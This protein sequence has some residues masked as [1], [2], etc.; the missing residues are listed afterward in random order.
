MSKDIQRKVA[1]L[2]EGSH[3]LRCHTVPHFGEYSVGKHSYD[4]LTLLFALHPDPSVALIKAITY[5]DQGERW[6]GDIPSPAFDGRPVFRKEFEEAQ[7]F[8]QLV[9]TGIEMPELTQEETNWLHAT[10]KV[11]LFLWAKEQ[12]AM[13]NTLVHGFIVNLKRT[14]K[15]MSAKKTMPLEMERFLLDYVGFERINET[16]YIQELLEEE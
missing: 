5:H 14:F 3:V 7:A 16:D 1:A 12:A 9:I 4:M 10:D 8:G 11:E 6:V 13:G 15:E 2:R